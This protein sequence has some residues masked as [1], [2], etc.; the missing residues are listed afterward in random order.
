MFACA[1]NTFIFSFSL[2][3]SSIIFG[4]LLYIIIVYM[5]IVDGLVQ[6]LVGWLS[7]WLLATY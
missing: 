3:A 7:D 6:L 2:I 1:R 4:K 5:R